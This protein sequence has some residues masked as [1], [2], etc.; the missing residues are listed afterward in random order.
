MRKQVNKKLIVSLKGKIS[1]Q[2]DQK[3][4]VQFFHYQPKCLTWKNNLWSKCKF[5][6]C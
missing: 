3:K 6:L 4:K 5:E 2:G 1:G